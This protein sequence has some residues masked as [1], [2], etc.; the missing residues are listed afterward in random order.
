MTMKRLA[1]IVIATA[2]SVGGASVFAG[3][4]Q[5]AAPTAT[6]PPAPKGHQIFKFSP[7]GKLLLTM[8]KPGGG[9]D[10][11]FFWQP[12][13]ILVAPDGSIFVAEGHSSAPGSTARVMKFSKDGALIR[14]F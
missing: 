6:P 1:V 12:N 7:D 8:G 14:S 4:P 11:D 5:A 3:L 2:V 9:R 13:D 10:P